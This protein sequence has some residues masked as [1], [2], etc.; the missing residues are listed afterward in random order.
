[1]VLLKETKKKKEENSIFGSKKDLISLS[2][3]HNNLVRNVFR[4]VSS[5]SSTMF[6]SKGV[7]LIVS[8]DSFFT[9]DSGV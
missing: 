7:F 4:N 9:E 6:I 3:P 8:M 1:M 2:S 5:G